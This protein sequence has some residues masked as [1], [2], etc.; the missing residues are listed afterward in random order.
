M[1]KSRRSFIISAAIASEGDGSVVF[2]A[3]FAIVL[4]SPIEGDVCAI[5]VLAFAIV[6]EGE[7]NATAGDGVVLD[8]MSDSP[9]AVGW[10]D[11][12]SADQSSK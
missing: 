5:V 9:S 4:R 10:T 1:K 11:I 3:V 2:V 8:T 6:A 12:F 7:D